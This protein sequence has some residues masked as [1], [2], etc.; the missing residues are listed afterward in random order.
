MA[1]E[2]IKISISEDW[3]AVIA[4]FILIL[5]AAVGLLGKNGLMIPF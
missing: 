1:R 4:A 3:W 5:L 2:P